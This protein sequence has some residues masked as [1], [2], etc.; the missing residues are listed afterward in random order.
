VCGEAAFDDLW[1]ET[2]NLTKALLHRK[3]GGGDAW[4]ALPVSHWKRRRVRPSLESFHMVPHPGDIS[5][6]SGEEREGGAGA[7]L[8]REQE[9][10]AAPLT[11]E[12]EGG[13]ALLTLEP[14]QDKQK[15]LATEASAAAEN[16]LQL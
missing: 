8:T 10:R 12:Q 11:H 15:E 7:L 1:D 2:V 5:S 14:S 13:A 6:E 16:L 3:G 9:G 4:D